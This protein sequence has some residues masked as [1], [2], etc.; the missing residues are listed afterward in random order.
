M[1]SQN[2]QFAQTPPAGAQQQW[3]YANDASR[4]Q[5]VHDLHDL[6]ARMERLNEGLDEIT[7]KARRKNRPTSGLSQSFVPSPAQ[8]QNSHST[9]MPSSSP[10]DPNFNPNP[11]YAPQ[12]QQF[13]RDSHSQFA[14]ESDADIQDLIEEGRRARLR[15]VHQ[16]RANPETVSPTGRYSA[17]PNF[18][19][20]SPNTGFTHATSRATPP[21]DFMPSVRMSGPE[22]P[23]H[24]TGRFDSYNDMSTGSTMPE[25]FG[26]PAFASPEMQQRARRS[27]DVHPSS[28]MHD[29]ASMPHI[30]N[31]F[32]GRP[33][34]N[35][36]SPFAMPQP[37]HYSPQSGSVPQPGLHTS[38]A[39]PPQM[40]MPMPFPTPMQPHPQMPT[41]LHHGMPLRMHPGMHQGF[42]NGQLH[43]MNSPMM[44]PYGM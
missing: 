39:M 15:N 9:T 5:E 14:G 16:P 17:Q 43:M 20:S 3:Q 6:S 2:P 28:H 24:P 11:F 31:G 38:S 18:M 27:A 41:S 7:N 37:M 23:R 10:V 25:V 29:P 8:A 36:P 4:F 30:R 35:F 21:R 1:A 26:Q 12:M 42:Q 19:P 34:F 44:M 13:D 22:M 32:E 40:Q 33:S